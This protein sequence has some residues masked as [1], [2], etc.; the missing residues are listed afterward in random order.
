MQSCHG[1]YTRASFKELGVWWQLSSTA[2]DLTE[3]SCGLT[4][5]FENKC[6]PR[7]RKLPLS[8]LQLR[9]FEKYQQNARNRK[10]GEI[11]FGGLL[12]SAHSVWKRY[13]P[14]AATHVHMPNA[15]LRGKYSPCCLTGKNQIKMSEVDELFRKPAPPS[16]VLQLPIYCAVF[17]NA[18][19]IDLVSGV[20]Y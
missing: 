12:L 15:L 5:C 6:W 16:C 18:A 20:M 13:T 8:T 1:V 3:H 7:P 14:H 9:M 10:P 11:T 2:K 19:D 17:F 4:L